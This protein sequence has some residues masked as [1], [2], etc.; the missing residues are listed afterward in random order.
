MNES[1][2]NE[3]YVHYGFHNK[4]ICLEFLQWLANR[5]KFVYKEEN[6][7]VL[8]NVWNVI[9]AIKRTDSGVEEKTVE[10]ICLHLYPNWELESD[11]ESEFDV[12]FTEEERCK[13]RY[14]IKQVIET[15][16]CRNS[17]TSQESLLST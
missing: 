2:F 7:D 16:Q 4:K 13:T 11:P 15:Y 10:R 14:F 12:G 5:L 6:D 17:L 9:Y 3:K 8:K 1:F